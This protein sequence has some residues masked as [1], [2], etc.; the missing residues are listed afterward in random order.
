MTHPGRVVFLDAEGAEVYSFELDVLRGETVDARDLVARVFGIAGDPVALL[1][2]IESDATFRRAP[3]TIPD[4]QR[5]GS[6]NTAPRLEGDLHR[7]PVGR[8]LD[9]EELA[10]R[11]PESTGQGVTGKTWIRVL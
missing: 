5:R 11:E 2:R 4:D 9:L 3:R 1:A 8:V 6:P 10:L 7:L